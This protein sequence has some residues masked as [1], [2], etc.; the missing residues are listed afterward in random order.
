MFRA[1]KVIEQANKPE[2]RD[3]DCVDVIESDSEF[4]HGDPDDVTLPFASSVLSLPFDAIAN[5]N[6]DETN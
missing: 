3:E 4:E 6:E 2:T 1:G 5:R